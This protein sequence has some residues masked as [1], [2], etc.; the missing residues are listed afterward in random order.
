MVARE[1]MRDV[2]AHYA[3][4]AR[5]ARILEA[6]RAAGPDDNGVRP[7]DLAPLDQFHTGGAAATAALATLAGVEAGMHV[8]DVGGG[9][10]GAARFLAA[11]H[12]CRVTVLDV[13]EAYCEI[14]RMLTERTGLGDRVRF[15]VGDALAMPF[16][17]GSFDRVWMQH[18][19]MNIPDKAALFRAVSRVLRPGGRLALHEITAGPVSPAHFPVPWA[20]SASASFLAAPEALRGLIARAGLR[21]RVWEDVTAMS[22]AW[23]R[24]RA[25]DRSAGSPP[26]GLHLLLGEVFDAAFGNTLRNLEEGRVTVVQGVFE[27]G[28]GAPTESA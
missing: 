2:V 14:G 19:S 6:V 26:L 23:F 11:T 5:T 7:S 8:L 15:E 27:R 20:R 10:G 17:E 22:L 18:S 12:G 1:T 9:L 28:Q 16:P 21:E 25:P 13:T 4:E 24:Q 3:D